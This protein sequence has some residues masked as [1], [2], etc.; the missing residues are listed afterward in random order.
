MSISTRTRAN[1]SIADKNVIHIDI[2]PAEVG[3][4]IQTSIPIVGDAKEILNELMAME[5]S[6]DF[7]QWYE[8]ITAEKAKNNNYLGKE[9]FIVNKLKIISDHLDDDAIVVADVGN[10]QISAAHNLMMNGKRR[11]ITSGGLGTMG[12]S[13]PASIGAQ[14]SKIDRQILVVIGDGAFQM[15]MNEL[16][17]LYEN[18][19]NVK[20]LLIDNQSLGMVRDLQK[21]WYN[22]TFS[23]NFKHNPNFEKICEANYISYFDLNAEKNIREFLAHPGVA[24]GRINLVGEEH[25]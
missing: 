1:F 21:A 9:T 12:F 3:K 14:I 4:K 6:T 23:V 25:E 18:E 17:T 5:Y 19:L 8:F 2:D 15:V 22:H 20:I 7:S 16:I 13:L 11:F 10:N 24:L